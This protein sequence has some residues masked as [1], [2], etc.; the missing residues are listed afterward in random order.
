MATRY[1]PDEAYPDYQNEDE[2]GGKEPCTGA[3]ATTTATAE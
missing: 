2:E 3:P 1:L